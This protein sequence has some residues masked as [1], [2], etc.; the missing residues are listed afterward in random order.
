MEPPRQQ[1]RG[2]AQGGLVFASP[3]YFYRTRVTEG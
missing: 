3:F 2:L 1:Q